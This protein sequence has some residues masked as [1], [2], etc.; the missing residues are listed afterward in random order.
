MELNEMN[1]KKVTKMNNVFIV[2]IILCLARWI[3]FIIQF[4]FFVGKIFKGIFA[5]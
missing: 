2:I 3:D 4:W 1:K 5:A